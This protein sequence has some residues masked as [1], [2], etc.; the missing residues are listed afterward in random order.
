MRHQAYQDDPEPE[1]H[2]PDGDI[3]FALKIT[4]IVLAIYGATLLA[5]KNDWI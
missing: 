4:L 2:D 5:I 1:R 3:R